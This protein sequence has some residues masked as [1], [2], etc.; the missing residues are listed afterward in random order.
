ML[1]ISI[2][3]LRPQFQRRRFSWVQYNKSAIRLRLP[4]QE[5]W[6]NAY[7]TRDMQQ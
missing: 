7:E 6:A 5:I 3:I 4:E 1:Y 2:S